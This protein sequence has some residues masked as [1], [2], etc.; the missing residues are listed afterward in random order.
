MRLKAETSIADIYNILLSPNGSLKKIINQEGT[1][2]FMMEYYMS[3][4]SMPY[5]VV[6]DPRKKKKK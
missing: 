5:L 4:H 3:G 2:W 1:Y 6:L